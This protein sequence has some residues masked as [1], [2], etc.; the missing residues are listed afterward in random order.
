MWVRQHWLHTIAPLKCHKSPFRVPLNSLLSSM[1][2]HK[3]CQMVQLFCLLITQPASQ[4]GMISPS[5]MNAHNL[6]ASCPLMGV[7][8]G[9]KLNLSKTIRN[10]M[11][12]HSNWRNNLQ[13]LFLQLNW[14]A[15]EQVWI[16][17]FLGTSV[18]YVHPHMMWPHW[19]HHLQGLLAHPPA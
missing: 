11:L 9:L 7:R 15:I 14:K 13:P 1:T 6:S 2:S 16:F 5:W 4:P 17:K 8:N 19:V 12:L 3:S 18:N 10:S